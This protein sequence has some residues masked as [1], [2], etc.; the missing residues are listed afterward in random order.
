MRLKIVAGNA[1]SYPL[2]RANQSRD[3]W[4]RG[5]LIRATTG[6]GFVGMEQATIQSPFDASQRSASRA[7]MHPLPAAVMACR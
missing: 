5:G 6:G 7:A 3:R 1:S 4:S 2:A